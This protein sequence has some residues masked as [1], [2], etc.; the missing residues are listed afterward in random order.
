[1]PIID[2]TQKISKRNTFA[3]PSWTKKEENLLF[4]T[5]Q[6]QAPLPSRVL[7]FTTAINALTQRN[8]S[9]LLKPLPK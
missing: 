6:E 7:L 8:M 9:P 3:V 4:L 1:M 2:V 5:T